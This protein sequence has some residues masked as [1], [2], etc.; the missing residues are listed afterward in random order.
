MSPRQRSPIN[1]GLPDHTRVREGYYS[2]TSP[3][4]GEEFGLGRDRARAIIQAREANAHIYAK[5]PTLLARITTGLKLWG[6]WCN[7][8]QKIL[9]R[10][11]SALNTVK[12]RNSLMKRL[13]A[14]APA[15]KVASSVDTADC[16]RALDA[17][18]DAG[19]ARTAKAL[20][21][22]MIDCF[23]RMIAK[24]LRKDNPARVTD[25]VVATVNRARLELDVFQRLYTATEIP[26]FRNAIAL[27]L[28]SAQP[29]ECICAVQFKDQISGEWHNHRGKTDTRIRI[30]HE[31]RLDAFGMSLGEVLAQCRKTG[32]VSQYVI[33]RTRQA[34][35]ARLGTRLHID[36]LTRL[37]TSELAKLGIDWGD[38]DPP[39]F[40]EIRSLSERLYTAQGNVNTQD[41][42]GHKEARTTATYHDP[43][44][45]WVQVVV[46]K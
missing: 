29:R 24:G 15:D 30:P 31:L 43:R 12:T 19:K 18:L 3:E 27:A 23:D 33:H 6:E 4:T 20:R 8:F 41:L 21:S 32:V 25:A 44:G 34:K 13:R 26:E 2:W 42:L 28:V 9:D 35:G 17:A 45:E 37:F 14:L 40:H 11:P 5:R 7:D 36:I 39:T 22:L 46:R 16:A 38:K 1:Q 10:R